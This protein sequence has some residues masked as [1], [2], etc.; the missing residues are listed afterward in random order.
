MA[1]T[2]G[3]A[4]LGD[5]EDISTWSGI[6]YHLL[7]A[8]VKAGFLNGGLDLRIRDFARRRW[9]WQFGCILRAER[10]RGFQYSGAFS[11]LFAKRALEECS[12]KE[13]QEIISHSQ[14]LPAG[15]L[16]RHSIKT[17][18]Y[19]D[20]TLQD[21][22]E[23]HRM[24]SWLNEKTV[25]EAVNREID[26]YRVAERVVT[27]S[28]WARMSLEHNYGIAAERIFTVL[29]GA[30]L[31]E[32]DVKSTLGD[33]DASAVPDRFTQDRKFRIGF[34]GKDWRRKG[35]P[36]LLTAVGALNR[37]EIPSEV[38]VIGNMPQQFRD[39]PYVRA[40]GFIDKSKDLSRFIDIVGSCD[41]GCAP[42][43]EE[44]MGIAPL[45][46]L[47]LGVPVVCTAAGGLIGVCKAAGQASILLNKDATPE[48]LATT[49]EALAKNPDR[50]RQMR[51]AAWERKEY[52]SWDRSV[53]E[54]TRIWEL[55]LG[56]R[57]APSTLTAHS[58][59]A[60]YQDA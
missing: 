22:F 3:I 13:L 33:A 45:E 21:L 12:R 28:P 27:M 5:S 37:M 35:L 46:Y 7:H 49:F 26:S 39:C 41:L 20:S 38:V 40:E 42:S 47:R 18:F 4:A 10:P 60:V 8:G 14:V 48:E 15:Y 50:L 23:T 6:P 52:F 36:R 43:H 58:E 53:K 17:S 44:P 55:G 31:S 19:I 16:I 56:T 9:N 51:A 11:D 54:L 34:T 57:S 2:R 24:L 29:P 30:N 59:N 1:H 25:K 32:K